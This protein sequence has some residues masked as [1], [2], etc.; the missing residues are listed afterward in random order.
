LRA[1]ALF[2]LL[3]VIVA[4][5][6]SAHGAPAHGS[7]DVR[8]T[9][10]PTPVGGRAWTVPVVRLYD[11]TPQLYR[12]GIDIAIRSWNQRRVG[13]RF[14]RTS[15]RNLAHVVVGTARYPGLVSGRATLGMV[16]GAWVRLDTALI[17][18]EHEERNGVIYNLAGSAV[19]E[20]I[21]QVMAHELGHV[22]G[23]GHARGC[24]LMTNSGVNPCRYTPPKGMWPCRLQERRDV[25]A[26]ARRYGGA[27]IVRREAYCMVSATPAGRVGAIT[28]SASN[29]D[30]AVS[31]RWRE[32]AN[33]YGYVVA[34]S[35]GAGTCPTSPDGGALRRDVSIA[36]YGEGW[37][38][39]APRTSTRYCYAVWSRNGRG[40][41]TGPTRIFVDTRPP[42][43]PP[44]GNLAATV[45]GSRVQFTWINPPGTGVVRI[46]RSD[47][48]GATPCLVPP[49]LPVAQA[50]GGASIASDDEVPSGTWTYAATRSD[51]PEDD[52]YSD[53]PP[54]WASAP[55]CVTVGVP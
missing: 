9:V 14:A 15:R 13:I 55:V 18:T 24:S 21:A 16:R 8:A 41:L 29:R 40:T 17:A 27:G 50:V 33:R 43:P 30:R 11:N 47:Q 36:E 45:T 52:V 38:P 49:F 12:E 51:D 22:L 2:L 48:A 4:P 20:E 35:P 19:P 28:A 42:V 31:L 32:V 1:T 3:W 39:A 10:G 6:A 5:G 46:Y 54:E 37:D 44:I 26:A 7:G 34:R 23:L 25:V 53:A